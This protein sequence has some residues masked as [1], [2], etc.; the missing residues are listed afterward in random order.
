MKRMPFEHTC[1][2]SIL[3]TLVVAQIEPFITEHSPVIRRPSVLPSFIRSVVVHFSDFAVERPGHLVTS[4]FPQ[5][6]SEN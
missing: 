2:F 4:S 5:A 3:F 1:S 6:V